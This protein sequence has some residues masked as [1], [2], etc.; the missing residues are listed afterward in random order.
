MSGEGV[1][2]RGALGAFLASLL[3]NLWTSGR[4]AGARFLTGGEALPPPS[5]AT[6]GQG[7][8]E[9][10]AAFHRAG[11]AVAAVE[12]AT[13]G[14][15]VDEEEAWLPAHAAACD[16][17]AAALARAIAAPAPDLGALAGKLELVFAHAVEPGAVEAEVVEAVMADCRRLLLRRG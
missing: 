9:A 4:A 5:A 15:S 7:W 16:A 6:A 8:A 14:R 10:L 13:A 2:R 17:A 12:R 3:T 11:A 1:S